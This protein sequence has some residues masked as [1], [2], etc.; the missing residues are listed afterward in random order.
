MAKRVNRAKR[1]KQ[2]SG[3]VVR[4]GIFWRIVAEELD[5]HELFLG[6]DCAH[7]LS[8][9][10]QK[11]LAAVDK[12]GGTAAALEAAEDATRRLVREMAREAV[13]GGSPALR[14]WTL[15]NALKRLC[16]MWPFCR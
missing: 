5:K 1:T 9:E 15:N 12:R 13:R 8:L 6:E 4:S 2:P 16:P 11:A 7:N 3:P 10:I 14:E